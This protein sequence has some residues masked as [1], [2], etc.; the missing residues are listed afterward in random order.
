MVET[1][2]VVKAISAA[3]GATGR[4]TVFTVPAA[5]K[6]TITH[7]MMYFPTGNEGYLEVQLVAG[8]KNLYPTEGTARGDNTRYDFYQKQELLSGSVIEAVYTNNDSANAHGCYILLE[9]Y[10]ER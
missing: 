4:E 8:L 1:V 2:S 6:M 7:V 10:I 3:A 9:G 5:G